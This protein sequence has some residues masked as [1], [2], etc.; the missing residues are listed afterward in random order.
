MKKAK[1]AKTIEKKQTVNENDNYSI[2]KLL[3]IILSLVIVF[4]IFYFITTL[5]VKPSKKGSGTNNLIQEI[6]TTKITLNHL[7]DRNET[8]YYVLVTKPSL[9]ES[10]ILKINYIEIYNNYI[11]DYKNK[12]DSKKFY[13]V[14]LD[15][16]LNKKYASDDINISE[17]LN[18][19]KLND[20]ILFKISNH[21]ID[22]YY[23]GR[24]EIIKALSNL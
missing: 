9:Y 1:I 11:K 12:D 4:S 2:K 17:N 5:I 13:S 24:E 14:N 19:L 15:D 8:D 22:K 20:E 23:V 7:L 3:M 18:E 6:D 10:K 21:S 16:V